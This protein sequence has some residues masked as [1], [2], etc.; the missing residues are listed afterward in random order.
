MTLLKKPA[1]QQARPFEPT[2]LPGLSLWLRADVGVYADLSKTTPAT[3][4]NAVAIWAD[5][6]GNG[7]DTSQATVSARPLLRATGYGGS[8]ALQFDGISQTLLTSVLPQASTVY[9]FCVALQVNDTSGSRCLV[10]NGALGGSGGYGLYVKSPNR[11]VAHQGYSLFSDGPATLDRELWSATMQT[12]TLSVYVNGRS[13][14][15]TATAGVIAPAGSSFTLGSFLGNTEYAA[16]TIA[17]VLLWSRVL[18]DVDRR[19][20]ETYLN[21]RYVIFSGTS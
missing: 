12:S 7:R 1:N 14:F 21:T 18:S 11:V 2:I 13:Q 5:Q 15:T 17:E 20:V 9:T 4:G 3:N 16:V 8:P 6:S 19:Q 10:Y